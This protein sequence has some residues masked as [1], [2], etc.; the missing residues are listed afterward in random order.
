MAK[1]VNAIKVMHIS[2]NTMTLE[3]TPIVM[4]MILCRLMSMSK[5]LCICLTIHHPSETYILLCS[6][7]PFSPLSARTTPHQLFPIEGRGAVKSTTLFKALT[8]L[9]MMRICEY[10]L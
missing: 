5:S 2:A 4:F 6:F 1:Q 3:K 10:C 9:S 7:I 8:I